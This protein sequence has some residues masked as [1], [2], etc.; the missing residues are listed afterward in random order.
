MR[1]CGCLRLTWVCV[2]VIQWVGSVG[3]YTAPYSST[4]L[5]RSSNLISIA[6]SLV[7]IAVIFVS[8][9]VRSVFIKIGD[10]V[11]IAASLVFIA[12]ISVSIAV[13]SVTIAEISSRDTGTNGAGTGADEH[14]WNRVSMLKLRL[15]V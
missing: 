1:V 12:A 5:S 13:R 14:S 11:F 6:A 4:L 15:L 3:C 9:A 8:I 2:F 7:F 10:L